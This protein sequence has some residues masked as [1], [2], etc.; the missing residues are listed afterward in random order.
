MQYL[1]GTLSESEALYFS[2]TD[3]H[4]QYF[5]PVRMV[6]LFPINPPLV[7]VPLLEVIYW[8]VAWATAY[9]PV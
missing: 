9:L 7:I 6:I 3:V 1:N 4:A 8:Q 5:E 2:A